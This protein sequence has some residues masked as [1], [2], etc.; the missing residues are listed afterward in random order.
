MSTQDH[1]GGQMTLL[2]SQALADCYQRLVEA[3]QA[4][5][6][7]DAYAWT[8][9]VVHMVRAFDAAY[10]RSWARDCGSAD[11]TRH[12]GQRLSASPPQ[13]GSRETA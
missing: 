12:D 9:I 4:G 13:H 6:P 1:D 8:R 10:G 7:D 3:I 5:R 2:Q 11:G